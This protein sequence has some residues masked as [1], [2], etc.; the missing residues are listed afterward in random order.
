MI[1]LWRWP[2]RRAARTEEAGISSFEHKSWCRGRGAEDTIDAPS[3]C[4]PAPRSRRRSR[5]SSGRC[6]TPRA[7]VRVPLPGADLLHPIPR[8]AARSSA[9]DA[10][11]RHLYSVDLVHRRRTTMTKTRDMV[12]A[13]LNAKAAEASSAGALSLPAV[14]RPGL[15]GQRHRRRARLQALLAP[16]RDCRQGEPSMVIHADICVHAPPSEEK[17]LV[18]LA[19]PPPPPFSQLT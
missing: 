16:G 8:R 9:A 15:G 19:Q 5:R 2:S 1:S 11:T 6:R 17:L 14:L 4:T 18:W 13:T 10:V 3:C 12:R 7:A